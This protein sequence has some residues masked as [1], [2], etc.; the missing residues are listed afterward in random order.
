MERRRYSYSSSASRRI[1]VAAL[2]GF[3]LVYW[4]IS[5]RYNGQSRAA[6]AKAADVLTFYNELKDDPQCA[7]WFGKVVEAGASQSEISEF[8]DDLDQELRNRVLTR[9]NFDREMLNAL[10]TVGQRHENVAQAILSVASEEFGCPDEILKEGRLPESLEQ[11]RDRMMERLV[12]PEGAGGSLAPAIGE[13]FPKGAERKW[14]GLLMRSDGIASFQID[15]EVLRLGYSSGRSRFDFT[16][17]TGAGHAPDSPETWQWEVVFPTGELESKM[18]AG[19]DWAIEVVL[20]DLSV[21][22]PA[23]SLL[24]V[25]VRREGEPVKLRVTSEP[26]AAAAEDSTGWATLTQVGRAYGLELAAGDGSLSEGP[27]AGGPWR[28]EVKLPPG[29]ASD[30]ELLGIYAVSSE[31][32]W[33]YLGGRYLAARGTVGASLVELSK[34]FTL[35][36]YAARFEDTAGHWAEMEIRRMAARHVAK[37]IGGGRFDPDAL[38]TRAQ[39]SALVQRALGLTEDPRFALLY[40]DVPLESWY[41][42]AVG[43]LARLGAVG[44]ARGRA[45]RPDEPMTRE[46]IAAAAL[47][48]LG[49]EG[50]LP[51]ELAELSG[52]ESAFCE[53]FSDWGSVSPWA[54]A[55]MA[56][57][58]ELGVMVGRG[59][60]RV[61][62]QSPVTRAEAVTVLYRLLGFLESAR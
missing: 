22:F 5:P 38:V 4:G 23:R 35:A 59:D 48:A 50:V 2:S 15:P 20:G 60:G 10:I 33:R 21:S 16:P 39:G 57:A 42:G 12:G 56:R 3:L 30:P 49:R 19:S 7:R 8:L 46:E 24:S 58:A 17:Y 44:G 13:A 11:L 55:A 34:S 47:E 52:E 45:F 6:F 53:R 37:G 32:G 36:E 51:A 43:A 31:T 25:A 54:R 27:P 28:V 29:Y 1:A 9:S 61:D 26:R 40:E 18:S 14:F 62:P 41:A